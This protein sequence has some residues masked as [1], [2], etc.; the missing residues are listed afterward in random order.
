MQ[1]PDIQKG[2]NVKRLHGLT[3]EGYE[4]KLRMQ[5]NLCRLCGQEFTK[6]DGPVLD[7]NHDTLQF[8]DFIHRT[9][10]LALGN[11]KDDP[12]LCRKAAEYLDRHS[13]EEG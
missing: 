9:C 7:H 10:N 6:D 3:L 11:L 8:R 2:Y 4:A 1:N 5:D 13:L 12:E